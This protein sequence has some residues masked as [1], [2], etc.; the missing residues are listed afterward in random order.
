[1]RKID[2]EQAIKGELIDL[3]PAKNLK[4]ILEIKGANYLNQIFKLW[5]TL[6]QLDF[7]FQKLWKDLSSPVKIVSTPKYATSTTKKLLL[8]DLLRSK[9]VGHFLLHYQLEVFKR[10]K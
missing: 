7:S 6:E 4:T 5:C 3:I 10:K 9:Y 8:I 1:M 2:F